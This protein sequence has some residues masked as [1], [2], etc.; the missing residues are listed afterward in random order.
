MPLSGDLTKS[1]PNLPGYRNNKDVLSPKKQGF[2]M[3]HG[4]MVET[5][6]LPPS[7]R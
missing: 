4:M 1:F 5:A 2:K 6:A 3:M 7:T